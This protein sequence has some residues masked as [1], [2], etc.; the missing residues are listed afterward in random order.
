MPDVGGRLLA[1][2]IEGRKRAPRMIYMSGYTDDHILRHGLA[3]P[4]TAFL[5]KPFT[6]EALA[7]IVRDV[8]DRPAS[9]A[10]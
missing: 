2:C 4:G 10:A 1:E 9:S 7:R 5:Q 3:Q 8:L 6:P